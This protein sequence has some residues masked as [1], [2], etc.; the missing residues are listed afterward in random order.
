MD[1]ITHTLSGIAFATCLAGINT[2]GFKQKVWI[3]G[4]GAL[5][6]M[7]PDVDAISLWSRFDGTIGKFFGLSHSGKDIYSAKFWYSHHGFMHSLLG[8]LICTVIIGILIYLLYK[9]IFKGKHSLLAFIKKNYVLFIAFIGGFNL[10][11]LEDMITP[12]GSWGGVRYFFPSKTYIGGTGDI[13]WWNNYD[14]FLIVV[15]VILLNLMILTVSY[16]SRKRLIKVLFSVFLIGGI[17][18]TIQFKNRPFNFNGKAYDVCETQSQEIQ[19]KIL[20]SSL[21]ER[22]MKFDNSLKVYF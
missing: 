20:P 21:Y 5:G 17:L 15:I 7:L 4:S 16:F 11:L 22:M 9:W 19:K 12:G 13:W 14:L 10:H 1:I 8:S 6:G 18:F 2:R 3:I